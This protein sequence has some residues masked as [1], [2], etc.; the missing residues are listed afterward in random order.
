MKMKGC[1]QLGIAAAVG[2]IV[3]IGCIW[4]NDAFNSDSNSDSTGDI[5]LVFLGLI[6]I[7]ALGAFLIARIEGGS[8]FD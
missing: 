3:L 7:I 2:G 1:V 8:K 6:V 4:L 5:G